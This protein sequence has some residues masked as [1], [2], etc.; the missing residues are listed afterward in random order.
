MKMYRELTVHLVFELILSFY[1]MVNIYYFGYLSINLP[2]LDMFSS[3]YS[4]EKERR[5]RVAL[6]Y[7]MAR[8]AAI[9]A[10][11]YRPYLGVGFGPLSVSYKLN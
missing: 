1:Y 2:E 11:T 5:I 7:G 4:Y 3:D 8:M 10:S 9:M 6:I